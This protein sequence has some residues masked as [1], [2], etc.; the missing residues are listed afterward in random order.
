MTGT[1][2][3]DILCGSSTVEGLLQSNYQDSK[4]RVTVLGWLNL[5]LKDI[6]N[7]QSNWHWK[8]LEKTSYAP[9]V[10]G[11]IAY[12]LPTDIDTQKMFAIYD[13][14]DDITYS[15]VPYERFV[16]L[17][18]DPSNYNGGTCLWTLWAKTIRLF[19]IP[20]DVRNVFLDFIRLITPL[21]D[22][23]TACDIPAKYDPIIIDGVLYYGYQFMPTL[24]N[25]KNKQ[26]DYELGIERM[27]K[28]NIQMI[29]DYPITESHR[30]KLSSMRSVRETSNGMIIENMGR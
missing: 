14:T 17:V 16:K 25:Y 11:Q 22:N 9:T 24:A 30:G 2:F 13:R 12:D 3:L 7:R 10:S 29:A 21:S 18:P 27:I 6:Q 1:Q 4:F 28:D 26:Q 23:T 8:F 20:D 5:V 19:P 15:Y